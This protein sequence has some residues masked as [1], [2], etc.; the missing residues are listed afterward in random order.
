MTYES[1]DP[2]AVRWHLGFVDPKNE[3]AAVEQSNEATE[4]FVAIKSH[5]AKRVGTRTVDGETWQ[6]Y[7]GDKYDALVREKGGVTTMVTGTA[8]MARLAELAAALDERGGR[9]D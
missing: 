7:E 9:Q 8:P 1:T 4:K 5:Q 2:E 6:R 3:Y